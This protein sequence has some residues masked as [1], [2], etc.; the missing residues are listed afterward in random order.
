VTAFG[1]ILLVI[2]AV[3][4]VAEAHYPAH[5]IAGGLGVLAMAAGAVLAISG[6]GGGLLVA[7]LAGGALAGGGIGMVRLVLM[8]SENVRG[9]RVRT[10]P[11]GLI[12]H[13]GVVRSWSD[14]RGSVSLDGGVWRACESPGPDEEPDLLHPGDQVV[15]ERLSG[16]TV[17]VR[18]A[19]QWELL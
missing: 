18:R 19:E 16:L 13:I 17:S 6:L 15:V 4:A 9:R 2:G 11:E 12:G 10:G 5:G 7:L 14:G 3:I 1:L 8:Q